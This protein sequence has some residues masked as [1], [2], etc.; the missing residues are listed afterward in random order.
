MLLLKKNMSFQLY[1]S[2][3]ARRD[4]AKELERVTCQYLKAWN[5]SSFCWL[6]FRSSLFSE[7]KNCVIMV[8]FSRLKKALKVE[9]APCVP[10]KFPPI[11]AETPP[12]GLD[13]APAGAD[14]MMKGETRQGDKKKTRRFGNVAFFTF[15]AKEEHITWLKQ[16]K[17]SRVRRDCSW[18]LLMVKTYDDK[19]L[20]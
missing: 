16:R 13:E 14:V 5:T 17:W 3:R 1:I 8:L 20:D 9:R 7:C 6:K 11:P 10:L 2:V 12:H 15:S 19:S 4:V 18:L